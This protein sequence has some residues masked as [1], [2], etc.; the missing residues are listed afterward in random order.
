MIIFL[1]QILITKPIQNAVLQI[2]PEK[3]LSKFKL[4]NESHGFALNRMDTML[5]ADFDKLLEN[6]P[7]EVKKAIN[8]K[9]QA[10]GI[11]INEKMYPLYEIV[12][13]RHRIARAIYENKINI[14]AI[15]V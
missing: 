13:G 7:I 5:T 1:E 4:S 14:N 9:G 11:K 8:Q 12:N 3:D 6:E 10:Y 15:L 2:A